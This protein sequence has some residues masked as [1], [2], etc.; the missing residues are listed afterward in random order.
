MTT[1]KAVPTPVP[2]KD[3]DLDIEGQPNA[4][5]EETMV[6]KKS[7]IQKLRKEAADR[8]A[9]LKSV[10][11]AFENYTPEEIE[12]YLGAAEALITNPKAAAG[13]FRELAN[14]YDPDDE[15]APTGTHPKKSQ[16]EKDE[17]EEP[18][19]PDKDNGETVQLTRKEL[20]DLLEQNKADIIKDTLTREARREAAS[21]G[22]TSDHPGLPLFLDFARQNNGDMKEADKL[23]REAISKESERLA[24]EKVKDSEDFPRRGRGSGPVMP[25]RETPK[26]IEEAHEAAAALFA[27]SPG[28]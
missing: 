23:Y 15:V 27:S 2:D 8:R 22:Y 10:A 18:K 28:N 5:D 3:D 1:K 21:L 6:Y 14:L 17:N 25:Q 20:N 16:E 24:G 26:T 11:K 4:D 7:D 12:W 13:Q 9:Q 19:V